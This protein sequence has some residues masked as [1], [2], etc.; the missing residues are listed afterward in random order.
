MQLME[1]SYI[2]KVTL[3]LDFSWVGHENGYTPIHCDS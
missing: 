3:F 1:N 2:L